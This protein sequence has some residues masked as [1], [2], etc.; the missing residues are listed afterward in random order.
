MPASLDPFWCMPIVTW[1]HEVNK[2]VNL[3]YFPTTSYTPSNIMHPVQNS[4]SNQLNLWVVGTYE[5]A[6]F[7][8]KVSI[9]YGK[10]STCSSFPYHYIATNNFHTLYSVLPNTTNVR[11]LPQGAHG[12]FYKFSILIW[13]KLYL[14]LIFLKLLDEEAEINTI[15]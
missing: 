7:F 8:A 4:Q 1:L 5:K 9:L 2:V 11:R 15:R 12:C 3:I 13:V 6:W 14:V 10:T